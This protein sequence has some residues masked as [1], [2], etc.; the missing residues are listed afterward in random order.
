MSKAFGDK[1]ATKELAT[2]SLTL[3]ARNPRLSLKESATQ[4]QI[5]KAL[6]STEDVFDLVHKIATSG[7]LLAGE[8]LIVV[9]EDGAHVVLE[10]NRRTTAIQILRKP[11]LLTKEQ[12]KRLP[13]V[14]ADLKQ[15]LA[16]LPVDIA[17]NR[18]SAEPIL[19][20]RHTE[21]GAKPWSTLANMRR[22]ARYFDEKHSIDS[23]G[24]ILS[25]SR[26]RTTQ[27]LKG[28]KL[29]QLAQ[30]A[31]GWTA[32]EKIQLSD[33]KLITSGFTRFF[34]L[35]DARISMDLNFD[36]E[37]QPKSG[38][39]KEQL[40]SEIQR[41]AKGFLIK[42]AEGKTTFDTRSTATEVL[43]NKPR[44]R[45][46]VAPPKPVINT[47]KASTFFEKIDCKANDDTLIKLCKE[48]RIV[49]HIEMPVAAT[50]L[51]RCT[52]ELSLVYQVKKKGKWKELLDK[53]AGKDPTLQ[54]L[55]NFCALEKNAIFNETR[56]SNILNNQTARDSKDYLD[57]V[58]HGRWVEA[59]SAR[60]HSIANSLRKV[61]TAIVEDTQ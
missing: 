27:L 39:L 10:G 1:W 29:L 34:T 45:G 40:L 61:I 37:M 43:E 8:R 28:Y 20:K 7:G 6:L 12:Q 60:L 22:V 46:S 56:V 48:L 19:T 4:E 51:L 44:V 9:K 57:T 24:T 36:D 33:P 15:R 2:D 5:R 21:R 38:H 41:I 16:K 52:L 54:Q 31:P 35:R 13:S 3:D 47:P 50:M 42:D 49:N 59:D 18:L 55:F 53:N 25:I 26:A 58:V 23:I 11:S 14:S 30:Q 17:P 32:E